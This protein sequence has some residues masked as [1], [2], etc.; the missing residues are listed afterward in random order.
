MDKRTLD[1]AID[2][3]WLQRFEIKYPVEPFVLAPVSAWRH[4]DEEDIAFIYQSPT[5]TLLCVEPAFQDEI[6]DAIKVQEQSLLSLPVLAK[7]ELAINDCDYYLPESQRFSIG[8]QPERE[9]YQVVEWALSNPEHRSKIEAFILSASEDDIH[10]ADFDIESEYFY[11]VIINGE[12]AGMLASYCGFE[13]FEALSILVL[14]K[15]RGRG[16]GKV[17]LAS[18]IMATEK[19]QRVIRYRT[20]ADNMASI[21]LCESLGFTCHSSIQIISRVMELK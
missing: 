19:R 21:K 6:Q 3:S 16:V 11:A 10:K 12:T 1:Q 14:P 13:P 7:A 4:K 2:Q 9:K 18:L 20:N 15:Y 17:L 8:L 5:L